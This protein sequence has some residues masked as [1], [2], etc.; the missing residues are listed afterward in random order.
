ME[1]RRSQEEDEDSKRMEYSEGNVCT[2]NVSS[3]HPVLLCCSNLSPGPNSSAP[4]ELRHRGC[5][6]EAHPTSHP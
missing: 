6:D 1:G 3:C 4:R 5:T 2:Y